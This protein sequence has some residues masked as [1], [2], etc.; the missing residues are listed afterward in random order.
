MAQRRLPGENSTTRRATEALCT[1]ATLVL[2]GFVDSNVRL[3]FIR[4]PDVVFPNLHT[5]VL[6]DCVALTLAP[7]VKAFPNLAHL[8]LKCQEPGHWA[9]VQSGVPPL[10]GSGLSQLQ[11]EANLTLPR[12]LSESP[13]GE[14][15][16]G[17][18]KRLQEYVGPLTDHSMFGH[19]CPIARQVLEDALAPRPRRRARVRAPLG[20]L[21]RLPGVL[22][23]GRPRESRLT[24][25]AC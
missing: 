21:D 7:C 1:K 9:D 6:R 5:L 17:S 3:V 23:G 19:T 18:W 25:P 15:L 24:S 12:R 11:R 13:S 14:S 22:A 20:A 16:S 4:P 8:C 10:P 2:G